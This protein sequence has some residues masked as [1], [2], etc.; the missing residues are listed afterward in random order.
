MRTL[1]NHGA[2]GVVVEAELVLGILCHMCPLSI[3]LL[4]GE[5]TSYLLA[6]MPLGLLLIPDW[7]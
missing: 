7:E 6:L 1:L 5:V 2:T 3:E 4:K